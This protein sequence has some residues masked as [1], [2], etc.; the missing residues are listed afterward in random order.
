MATQVAQL[1]VDPDLKTAL[2]DVARDLAA[3]N[4][5]SAALVADV[6]AIRAQV[7]ALVAD[8]ATRISEHNTLVAKLNA[9][10]GVTDTN[11]AVAAAKTAVDPA[12][13]T[14]AAPAAPS[15]TVV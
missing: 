10:A 6:A 2:G 1:K 15:V 4:T 12:A 7:V 8:M 14:S 9:D 13:Q 3:V 5:P 11:Y